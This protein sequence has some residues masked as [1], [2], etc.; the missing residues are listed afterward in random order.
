MGGRGSKK[1]LRQT[2][3]GGK[4]GERRHR[5]ARCLQGAGSNLIVSL[6]TRILR[7]KVRGE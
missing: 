2:Y 7:G 1:E 3:W 4:Q 6:F 5:Y